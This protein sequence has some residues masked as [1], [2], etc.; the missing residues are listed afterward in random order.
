MSR[1][2]CIATTGYR[3]LHQEA[4]KFDTA[5]L[6]FVSLRHYTHIRLLMINHSERTANN[7]PRSQ[8][9]A[10]LEL[11]QEP[12]SLSCPFHLPTLFMCS[13]KEIPSLTVIPAFAAL[14][15]RGKQEVRSI[16]CCQ[17]RLNF[18]TRR[19]VCGQ[20]FG[21]RGWQGRFDDGVRERH[22][23]RDLLRVDIEQNGADAYNRCGMIR[24]M[25]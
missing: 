16:P 21:V 9:S 3:R 6:V 11:N 17:S 8:R 13:S 23:S 14:R 19:R 1:P 18:N 24:I 2:S 10:I 22:L 25:R 15:Q 7:T 5:R 12:Q 4:R 20:H